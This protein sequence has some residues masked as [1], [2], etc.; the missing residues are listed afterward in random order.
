MR[1]SLQKV[2]TEEAFLRIILLAERWSAGVRKAIVDFAIPWNVTRLGCGAEYLFT[3][4]QP[5]IGS[6]AH[7]AMDFQLRT[8]MHLY[9]MN[10][11]ILLTPFHN[12]ALMSA[13]TE[14]EDVDRHS[15]VFRDA[16]RELMA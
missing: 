15:T 8:G 4:Q 3:A 6:E 14:P 9:A 2:L 7:A 5:G 16:V 10:R 12:M 11:G 13:A 1:A